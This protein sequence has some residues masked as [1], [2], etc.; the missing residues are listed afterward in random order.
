MIKKK[1]DSTAY[2][3]REWRRKGRYRAAWLLV[4]DGKPETYGAGDHA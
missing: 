3:G 2:G 4:S 1:N